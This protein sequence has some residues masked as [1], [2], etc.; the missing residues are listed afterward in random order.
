MSLSDVKLNVDCAIKSINVK[1]E[2]TKTRLMELGLYEGCVVQVYKKS[3]FKKT[4]LII[5]NFTC[6]TLKDSIA[7]QIEVVYA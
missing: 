6:F 2:K 7:N 5:F 1:D 3:V 4:L